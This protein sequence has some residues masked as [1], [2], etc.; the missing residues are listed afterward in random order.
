MKKT[1][2]N[3]KKSTPERLKGLRRKLGFSQ[4]ALAEELCVS[5]SAVALWETGNR[6]LSG[7]IDKLLHLYEVGV[8]PQRKER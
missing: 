3:N 1:L 4:R 6:A 5:P 7:P 8:L 2:N